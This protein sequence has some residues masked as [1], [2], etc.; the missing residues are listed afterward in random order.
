[1]PIFTDYVRR[2]HDHICIILFNIFVVISIWWNWKLVERK[3]ISNENSKSLMK[4]HSFFTPCNKIKLS[5]NF[6]TQN[7][8]QLKPL[9]R[10]LLTSLN[11]CRGYFLRFSQRYV[12]YIPPRNGIHCRWTFKEYFSNFMLYYQ[13]NRYW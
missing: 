3:M 8:V 6:T 10:A 12:T 7:N 5:N 13:N 11:K 2:Y 9:S 1:M 4:G